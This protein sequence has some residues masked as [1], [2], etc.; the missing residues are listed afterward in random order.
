MIGGRLVSARPAVGGLARTRFL[1]DRFVGDRFAGDRFLG[2]RLVGC[3]RGWRRRTAGRARDRSGSGPDGE[4][5]SA[6][7]IGAGLIVASLALF[8]AALQLGAVVVARHRA[9]AAADLAALAAATR[10]VAGQEVACRSA[11]GVAERMSAEVT[12]CQLDGWDAVVHVTA[13]AP[14]LVERFGRVQASA[15]AGPVDR[16][17]TGSDRWGSDGDRPEGWRRLTSPAM[18]ALVET[19]DERSTPIGERR[20]EI[21]S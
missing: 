4:R 1:G 19:D 11:G 21:G 15:R 20:N 10:A 14:W 3:W 2:D 5:G 13:R 18:P 16:S 7:V 9:E 12:A 6:T 8:V 17:G